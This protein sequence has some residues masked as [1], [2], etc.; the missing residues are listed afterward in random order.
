MTTTASLLATARIE[1]FDLETP[2]LWSDALL[3]SYID[4]A[5][6]QFCRDTY[7]IEDSRTYSLS[8]LAD[9]TEW[10][11]INA[12]ILKIRSAVN[13]A[14][15][16][17]VDLIAVEKMDT[18]YMKF[19][20][21]QGPI[22][23]LITGLDKGFVRA[24]PVPNEAAT[25]NLRTFVLPATVTSVSSFVIDDQHVPYLLHWVKYRA[26]YVQDADARDE[27]KADNNKAMWDAYCAKAKVEQSRARRP[28]STVTYGG[29]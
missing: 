16:K 15:G 20:G 24:Y 6:K 12:R 26:Y 19:D 21:A 18:S 14:T 8:I 3:Y 1:L 22:K 11:A 10:Y 29:I 7:G 17:P 5:Q 27:K 2:Y 9:G 4:E 13:S 25:I 23:A 28:V